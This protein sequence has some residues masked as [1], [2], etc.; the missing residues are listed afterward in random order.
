MDFLFMRN[1]LFIF[2]I[3]IITILILIPIIFSDQTRLYRI[4]TL[5]SFIPFIIFEIF[6]LFF[7]DPLKIF[8]MLAHFF[9]GLLT[10]LV[11]SNIS[12]IKKEIRGKFSLLITFL[13]IVLI[14][15]C[16][17][18]TEYQI[19]SSDILI[20]LLLTL[21]GGGIGYILFQRFNRKNKICL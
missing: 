12:R 9:G 14:E 3:I 11:F 6:H 19:I 16:L 4:I 5:I 10:F 17:T 13:I 15:I 18:L 20:D 21:F 2:S 1:M 7:P 8:D